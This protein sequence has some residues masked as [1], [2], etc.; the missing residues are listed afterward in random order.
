MAVSTLAVDRSVYFHYWP[1]VLISY[2]FM[3]GIVIADSRFLSQLSDLHQMNRCLGYLWKLQ[4]Q[5]VLQS[6][7]YGSN[8]YVQSVYPILFQ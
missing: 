1:K 2:I 6:P 8:Q 7:Q 4:R 3:K 5:S